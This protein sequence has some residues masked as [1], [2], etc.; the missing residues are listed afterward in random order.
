MEQMKLIRKRIW[1]KVLSY[2]EKIVDLAN[3]FIVVG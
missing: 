1:L 2:R 3:Q